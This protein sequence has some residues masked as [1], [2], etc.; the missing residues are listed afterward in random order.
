MQPTL[1]IVIVVSAFS[2]GL[3]L[4]LLIVKRLR[5]GILVSVSL[6]LLVAA[7]VIFVVW[8]DLRIISIGILSLVSGANL[9]R[10]L[11]NRSSKTDD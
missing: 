7:V 6:G 5:G 8:Y 9:G 10:V 3:L 1:A 4:A 2:L 11:K